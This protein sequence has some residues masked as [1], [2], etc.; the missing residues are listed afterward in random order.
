MNKFIREIFNKWL[1]GAIWQEDSVVSQLGNLPTMWCLPS[2]GPQRT[3][4]QVSG[5]SQYLEWRKPETVAW[6]NMTRMEHL[7]HEKSGLCAETTSEM[8]LE[9]W[10]ELA[11]QR[12]GEERQRHWREEGKHVQKPWD[13]N[14]K[15]AGKKEHLTGSRETRT[16][17]ARPWRRQDVQAFGGKPGPHR[18]AMGVHQQ[19]N[20]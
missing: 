14:R 10:E 7:F 15:Q 9:Y 1:S 13:R 20:G 18:R 3:D 12:S 6:E 5:R 11:L 4:K 16:K 19:M 8:K 17:R 2:S